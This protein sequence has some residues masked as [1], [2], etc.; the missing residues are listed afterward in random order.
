[1]KKVVSYLILIGSAAAMGV[2][3][4]FIGKKFFADPEIHFGDLSALEVDAQAIV[5]KIDAYNGPK[6]KTEEFT[7]NEILNYSLEKFRS[8]ENCCSFTFG[9]A[10]TIVDQDIRGCL[11]KNGDRYFEESISK[12][13]MVSL[14]N[15]IFQEGK[16]A[17]VLLYSASKG[18]EITE[19]TPKADFSN[20]SPTAFSAADYKGKYGKTLDEM[21]IYLV[22]DETIVNSTVDKIESGY[23]FNVE[24]DPNL[25]TTNYKNQMKNVSNLDKLP[26]FDSVNLT[27]YL[28][29]NLLIQRLSIN[30]KYTATMGL[31]A[32]INGL[33][34]IYY[35]SDTFVQIPEVNGVVEYKKGV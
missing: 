11:I 1:M 33:L 21:F 12:S 19:D 25:S 4:G 30:E 28:D 26:S 17:D 23:K 20:L 2:A 3:A 34:D 10:D 18:I 24:L 5:R 35:F 6:D 31:P 32:N 16:D 22:C 9:V 29:S 27:F 15:R 13:S 7:A 14:A 8:C